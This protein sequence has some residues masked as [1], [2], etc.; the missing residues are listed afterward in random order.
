VQPNSSHVQLTR[1]DSAGIVIEH[2]S[3]SR[4]RA[5][6]DHE[7]PEGAVENQVAQ[8]RFPTLK[9]IECPVALMSRDKARRSSSFRE[10]AAASIK[11]SSVRQLEK[12]SANGKPS[13]R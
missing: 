5:N 12:S 9:K 1:K 7:L 10:G 8:V 6:I 11:A 3:G 4:Q 2:P 13:S